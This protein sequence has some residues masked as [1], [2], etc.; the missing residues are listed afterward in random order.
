MSWELKG[1]VGIRRRRLEMRGGEVMKLEVWLEKRV[2]TLNSK[3]GLVSVG[4]RSYIVNGYIV[5]VG[6][7]ETR[8]M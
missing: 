7:D 1:G 8:E 4:D 2:P 5:V 6:R 3:L